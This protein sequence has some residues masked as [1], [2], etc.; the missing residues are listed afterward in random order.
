MVELNDLLGE[1]WNGHHHH[2]IEVFERTLASRSPTCIAILFSNLHGVK[3]A[4]PLYSILDQAAQERSTYFAFKLSTPQG[5]LHMLV[6]VLV[7]G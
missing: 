5:E 3:D 2:P 7:Q 4:A 1:V 6:R